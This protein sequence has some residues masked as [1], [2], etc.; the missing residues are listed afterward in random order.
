MSTSSSTKFSTRAKLRRKQTAAP[1]QSQLRGLRAAGEAFCPASACQSLRST[2]TVGVGIF[3]LL[4]LLLLHR[5]QLS[6]QQRATSSRTTLQLAPAQ[7]VLEMVYGGSDRLVWAR[8]A[9]AAAQPRVV[10]GRF[11]LSQPATT[12][13]ALGRAGAASANAAADAAT[14]PSLTTQLPSCCSGTASSIRPMWCAEPQQQRATS[15]PLATRDWS[16]SPSLVGN[17]RRQEGIRWSCI[18]WA[19]QGRRAGSQRC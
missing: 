2:A 9:A 15:H 3:L 8:A 17:R 4:A 13:A 10:R 14:P 5:Q 19:R 7:G 11:N 6:G 12:S 1:N 18:S 16:V